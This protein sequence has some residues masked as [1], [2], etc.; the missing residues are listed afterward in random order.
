MLRKIVRI[1]KFIEFV[2]FRTFVV[3]HHLYQIVRHQ[4]LQII[5]DDIYRKFHILTNILKRFLKKN[6]LQNPNLRRQK[7]HF[8]SIK[9][10]MYE[11][12]FYLT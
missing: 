5:R 9:R 7:L 2:A 8:V 6:S 10:Q 3:K 12:L 1:Q 11:N 4:P